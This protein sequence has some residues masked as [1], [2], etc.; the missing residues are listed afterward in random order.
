MSCNPYLPAATTEQ[1][2]DVETLQVFLEAQNK[3][4]GQR[5]NVVPPQLSIL[6]LPH[7]TQHAGMRLRTAVIA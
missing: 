7:C 5:Q 1:V 4:D 6:L 2:T 3:F